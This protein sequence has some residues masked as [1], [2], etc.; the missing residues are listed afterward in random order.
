MKNW[1]NMLAD[2]PPDYVINEFFRW[3]SH[4]LWRFCLIIPQLF[5]GLPDFSLYLYH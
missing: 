4:L 3:I 1:E 2:R 5:I